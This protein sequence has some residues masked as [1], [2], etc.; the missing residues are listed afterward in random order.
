MKWLELARL[1]LILADPCGR[2]DPPCKL[3]S[4]HCIPRPHR[5]IHV[6]KGYNHLA[7]P[8]LKPSEREREQKIRERKSRRS[9]R[10]RAEDQSRVDRGIGKG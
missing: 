2:N 10:E 1:E 6:H 7:K 3:P 4:M 8:H 9:E 5:P